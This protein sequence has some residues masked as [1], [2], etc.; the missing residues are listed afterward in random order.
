MFTKKRF[1][2]DKQDTFCNKLYWKHNPA[3]HFMDAV[4][5]LYHGDAP[6]VDR[7]N[8]VCFDFPPNK[9]ITVVFEKQVL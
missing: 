2:P 3:L 7:E 4:V 5:S 1:F 9:K 8:K 6:F